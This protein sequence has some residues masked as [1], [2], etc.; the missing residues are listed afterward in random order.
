M[1]LIK[2]VKKLII[3]FKT[4]DLDIEFII[5]KKKK[6]SYSPGKKISCQKPI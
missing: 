4:S 3:L 6:N 5:S 2:I 1:K